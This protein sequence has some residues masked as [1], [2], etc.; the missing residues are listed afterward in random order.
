MP[1]RYGG[2]V[3]PRS[4]I[5]ESP[6]EVMRV[7]I[8]LLAQ[9]L[10]PDAFAKIPTSRGLDAII[11]RRFETQVK[12]YRW[13][14]ILSRGNHLQ[15]AADIGGRRISLQ[16]Y[17][18]TLA[19]PAMS[20][21]EAKQVSFANKLQFGCR[22]ENISGHVGRTAVMRNRRSKTGTSS[23]FKGVIKR[24]TETGK[25]HWTAS[26]ALK[27]V[28][29]NLGNHPSER[30]AA[31][32]HDAAAYLLFEN[33]ALY[34]LPDICPDLKALEFVRERLARQDARKSKRA[35][36]ASALQVED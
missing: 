8:E 20:L 9:S 30:Q 11:D 4:K 1:F 36:G 28:K 7:S 24:T 16:R 10:E 14:A 2:Y 34:N 29:Y 19:N 12:S 3:S 6:V 13:Y 33:A 5:I 23:G 15:A 35:K 18:V 21:D 27:D 26:I 31:I 25:V 22:L 32:T 17:I